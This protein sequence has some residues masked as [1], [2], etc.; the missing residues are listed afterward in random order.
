MTSRFD[1]PPQELD[2][3]QLALGVVDFAA[4]QG[5]PSAVLLRFG[6]QLERVVGRAGAAAQDADDQ[7]R[8]VGDQL[9]HRPRA[10]V[11]DLQKDR[12]PGYRDAGQ[13]AG[14]GIVDE[15]RRG[16]RRQPLRSIGVEDFQK[17]AKALALGLFAESAIVL[18][19]DQIVVQAVVER[20]AVQPQIRAAVSLG[21]LAIDVAALDVVE[22]RGAKGLRRLG[23]VAAVADGKYVA[24]VVGPRGGRDVAVFEQPLA[25]RQHVV[26]AGRHEHDVDQPLPRDL[27]DLFA[28]FGQ[29]AHPH[30]AGVHFGRAA[31]RADAERHVGI[32]G[33]GQDEL[34]RARRIGVNGG[35]FSIERFFHHE[36]FLTQTRP[37]C[38]TDSWLFL[39]SLEPIEHRVDRLPQHLAALA[40]GL[41]FFGPQFDLDAFPARRQLR[42][43]VGHRQGHVANAVAAALHDETGRMAWRS[44][45][46]ASITSWIARPTAKP[47]PPFFL[48]TSAPEPLVRVNSSLGQ[49]RRSSRE[50]FPAAGRRSCRTRPDRHHAVAMLAQD[51]G[52]DLRGRRGE[53]LG[54][55]ARKRIVSSCVPRPITCAGGRSSR[56]AAR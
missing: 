30:F 28:I 41:H 18:E 9:L 14:D 34:L 33:V 48:I 53:L 56:S 1:D 32:L 37:Y 27:A 17:V 12:P 42:P 51:Q 26:A 8:I 40:Q 54:N 24:G 45:A 31:R 19:R 13:S 49:M 16:F 11:D 52:L 2:E 35:Q 25:D 47:A 38:R 10:V 29:R 7:V 39:G 6:D 43:R 46:I 4:E 22:I 36:I 3:R 15:L 44:S 23:D 5:C 20:D 21:G 55:Q 50:I